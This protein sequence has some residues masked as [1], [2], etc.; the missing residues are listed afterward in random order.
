MPGLLK[1][2]I[3][4]ASTQAV[5]TSID[6]RELLQAQTAVQASE[7]LRIQQTCNSIDVHEVLGA[8]AGLRT[9]PQVAGKAV[10]S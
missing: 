8:I 5:G 6:W 4:E 3:S 10:D 7:R 2:G 1:S 9:R